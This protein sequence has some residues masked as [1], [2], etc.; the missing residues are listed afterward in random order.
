MLR[1][2]LM[3]SQ[4]MGWLHISFLAACADSVVLVADKQV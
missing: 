1:K 2:L 3:F 4:K